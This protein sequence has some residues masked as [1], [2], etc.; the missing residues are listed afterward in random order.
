MMN[1]EGGPQSW[2]GERVNQATMFSTMRSVKAEIDTVNLASRLIL[3]SY[4]DKTHPRK[5]EL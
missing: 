4:Q 3:C 2:C 1:Y 5:E